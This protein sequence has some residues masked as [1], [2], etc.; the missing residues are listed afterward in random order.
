MND[1]V[2]WFLLKRNICFRF[3][4]VSFRPFANLF[5]S[6]TSFSRRDSTNQRLSVYEIKAERCLRLDFLNVVSML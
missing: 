6:F 4:F 3:D 5:V 1:L 2:G